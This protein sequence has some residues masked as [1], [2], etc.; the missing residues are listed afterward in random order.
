M[1]RMAELA[2]EVRDEHVNAEAI[3]EM[4][5]SMQMMSTFDKLQ[6]ALHQGKVEEAMKEMEKFGQMLDELEKSLARTS[7]EHE[8]GEMRELQKQL[9]DFAHRL[10]ELEEDRAE[11]LE[12]TQKVRANDK[13]AIESR[14]AKKGA[15]FVARLRERVAEARRSL[16]GV[17]EER[18][19]FRQDD[20]KRAKNRGG[21][22]QG[23]GGEGLRSGRA[24]GGK[25]ARPLSGV[26]EE[27]SRQ[28]ARR[29]A[30]SLL[31]AAGRRRA[32]EERQGDPGR[33]R[34]PQGSPKRASE[35]LPAAGTER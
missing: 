14:L 25:G 34:T 32:A 35:S 5:E 15:D 18:N 1:Q 13:K 3:D 11:S 2:K 6:E 19:I 7:Q 21:S 12:D 23:A 22:R 8:G 33:G 27:F 17:S 29:P 30:L 10:D 20:V 9:G 26:A 28:G 16:E 24:V 4:V 31:L